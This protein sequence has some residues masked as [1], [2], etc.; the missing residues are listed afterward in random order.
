MSNIEIANNIKKALVALKADHRQEIDNLAFD[1]KTLTMLALDKNYKPEGDEWIRRLRYAC[2]KIRDL[3]KAY[4]EIYGTHFVGKYNPDN[5]EQMSR[6]IA[7]FAT[8]MI[9]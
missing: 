7:Q 8:A 5:K 3:D 2:L 1:I 9:W 6:Y 4:F